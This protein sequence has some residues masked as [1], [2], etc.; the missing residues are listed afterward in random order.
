MFTVPGGGGGGKQ[1]SWLGCE[2]D[3]ERF[4]TDAFCSVQGVA[5]DINFTG[6]NDFL[7][8]SYDRHRNLLT[9]SNRKLSCMNCVCCFWHCLCPIVT[10]TVDDI[11]YTLIINGNNFTSADTAYL[12]L[13]GGT[14]DGKQDA[15][16]IQYKP[17]DCA[18]SKRT[19]QFS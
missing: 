11:H 1:A 9:S 15:V 13:Y 4:Y 6:L 14:N 3:P 16:I 2:E 19:F 10:G 5:M 8:E 12:C 18:F 17:T 7:L